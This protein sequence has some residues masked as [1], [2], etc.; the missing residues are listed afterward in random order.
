MQLVVSAKRYGQR[1]SRFGLIR[2]TCAAE[3]DDQ[4]FLLPV[5]IDET[6]EATARVPDRFRERQWTRLAGGL[7]PADL[8]ERVVRLLKSNR[9]RAL[10]LLLEAAVGRFRVVEVE[11]YRLRIRRYIYD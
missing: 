3:A 9:A 2:A 1:G 7:T 8:A 5:V 4:P 6:S 10:R 11:L